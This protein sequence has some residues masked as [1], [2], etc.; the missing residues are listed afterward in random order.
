MCLLVEPLLLRLAP[1]RR[2]KEQL[3]GLGDVQ[4]VDAVLRLCCSTTEG[5]LL[6]RTSSAGAG[7]CCVRLLYSPYRARLPIAT[8]AFVQ[9]G[10]FP[11]C[12]LLRADRA[13]SG[14]AAVAR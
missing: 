10:N 3:V 13:H 14:F 8:L 2:L 6:G 5:G 4:F 11:S 7:P 1:L 9:L 12:L